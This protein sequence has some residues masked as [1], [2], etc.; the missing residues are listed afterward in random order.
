M[1]PMIRNQAWEYAR[2]PPNG[3]RQGAIKVGIV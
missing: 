3:N 2:N 1:A